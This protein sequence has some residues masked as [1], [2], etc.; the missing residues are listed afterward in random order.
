MFKW[1]ARIALNRL[2]NDDKVD[3]I[4]K[5][6]IDNKGKKKLIITLLDDL[7][8]GFTSNIDKELAELILRKVI[9]STGNKITAF[10]VRD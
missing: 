4:M 3:V 8:S 7:V 1:L 5:T 6:N 10:I 2:S 9:K